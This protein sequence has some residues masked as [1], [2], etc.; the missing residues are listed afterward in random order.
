MKCN[1]A[2][3]ALRKTCHQVDM[4][5]FHPVFVHERQRPVTPAAP[6]SHE[7][8]C[9][10]GVLVR[11]QETFNK[12]SR[13]SSRWSIKTIF[14]LVHNWDASDEDGDKVFTSRENQLRTTHKYYDSP[15]IALAN[16][17][18]AHAPIQGAYCASF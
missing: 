2:N 13:R 14:D 10:Q 8:L 17:I 4:D 1:Y 6:Y 7:M 15:K 18:S 3:E 16:H 11:L 5:D 12:Y 9:E